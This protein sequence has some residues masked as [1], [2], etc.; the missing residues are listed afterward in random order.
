MA[1]TVLGDEDEQERDEIETDRDSFTPATR[2]VGRGRMI[3]ESAWSF[4]DN[5]GVKETHSFPELLIRCGLTE[6]IELRLGWNYEIGGAGS[7]V[8]GAGFGEDASF[9]GTGLERE[10]RV[11]YGLKFAVTEANGLVPR[12]AVILQGFSP[13]RGEATDSQFVGTYV[14]GWELPR[15]WIFDAAF[16]YGAGSAENDRFSIWAPSAVLKVPVGE[17]WNIHAEYFGIF[18]SDK[19]K[20]FVRH[21]VSP[22]VHYLITPNFEVGARVGWG[23]NDQ[24]ARFFSNVGMGWRF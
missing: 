24:A 9:G 21:F 13:T 5:R 14:L 3:V 6:R 2:L 4:L 15:R 19:E 18:S 22:G 17:K 7:D 1:R 12:S 20:D 23:L 16:R 10:S 8:S 11:I